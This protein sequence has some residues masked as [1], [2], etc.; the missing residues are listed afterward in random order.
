MRRKRVGYVAAALSLAVA[1][2]V[3][4]GAPAAMA[5]E[6]ET[7]PAVQTEALDTAG[8]DEAVQ[9]APAPQ[10]AEAASAEAEDAAATEAD[11]ESK[12]AQPE[13]SVAEGETA[14]ESADAAAQDPAAEEQ[15]DEVPPDPQ[16]MWNQLEDAEASQLSL[17]NPYWGT[18]N[19][20]TAF[21]NG[22]GEIFASPAMLVVD[23]S[24]W[25]EVIDWNAFKT[26]NPNAAVILRLGYGSSDEDAMFA[27]NISEVKRL[28]I[29]Y[30]VYLYSYAYNADYAAREAQ[31]TGDTLAKYGADPDLGIF[32]D[33][34]AFSTWSG[35]RH[36]TTPGAYEAIVKRY[37]E[38]LEKYGWRESDI[39]LYSYTSYLQDELNSSYLHARTTWVAQY[40]PRLDYQI[41]ADG[42]K[43]WQ[44][45]ASGS[46]AGIVG[47]ADMSAFSVV[48]SERGI[49]PSTLGTKVTNL[50]EGD[51]LLVSAL[52]NIGGQTNGVINIAGANQSNGALANLYRLSASSNQIFHVVPNGDGSYTIRA[53]HSNKVLDASGPSYA[54]GTPII[55]WDA[56]GGTNQKWNIYRDPSGYCYIVSVYASNLN[57][58][59][60]VAGGK[61]VE[62]TGI[63][64]WSLDGS[65]AERFRFVPVSEYQPDL[66]GWVTVDGQ[67][68]WYDQGIRAEGKAIYDTSV[69]AWRWID[70]DGTIARSKDAYVPSNGGKWIRLDANGIMVKG[71]DCRNGGW[72]YFDPVTGA[73]TKGVVYLNGGKWVYYD[74]VTGKMAHGEAFLNYDPDHTGWYLF[75]QYTGAMYHGDTFVRSSGGKWV[76]YDRTTGK[77]VKGLQY[78][79][80][81]WYYFDRTAGAMAH[82]RAWV[83]EW[84]AWHTFDRITGRG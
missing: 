37:Y 20:N 79:D 14:G 38:T 46:V 76:R 48:D 29:P 64:L 19:G 17:S 15:Q 49:E 60:A 43:G 71:E 16:H 27:R 32:Y 66:D 68:Y 44:Y 69:Q 73:M 74:V 53:N 31:L 80:G 30:G 34:E 25:Q 35:H 51:Y 57:K 24:A 11:A 33:L 21:F 7:V 70:P 58:A 18:V 8:A 84:D 13:S 22:S 65:D 54:N 45:T 82:G 83:P 81:A 10:G 36:P 61:A 5:E 62:G 63:Q 50:A 39:H 78:Q 72:Y 59:M 40:G 23:V 28:G 12:A 75:D 4:L 9:D 2:A 6:T 55:Q 41:V 77:M 26:A 42:Q 3:A 52:S 56:D 67:T 47:D 1:S